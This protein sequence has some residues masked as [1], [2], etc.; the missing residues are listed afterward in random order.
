VGSSDSH[1]WRIVFSDDKRWFVAPVVPHA[2]P[3]SRI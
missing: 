1:Y 2:E 3:A